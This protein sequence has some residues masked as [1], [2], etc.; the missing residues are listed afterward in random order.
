MTERMSHGEYVQLCRARAVEIASAAIGGEIPILLAPRLLSDALS[1]ADVP[2]D[3][4]DFVAVRMVDSELDGL[5][6]GKERKLWAPEA[7]QRLTPEIQAAQVWASPQ[8]YA[9]CESIVRRFGGQDRGVG[10]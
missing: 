10:V 1:G 4:A 2:L 8:V 9:V 6:I 3:D 5:P 7:L